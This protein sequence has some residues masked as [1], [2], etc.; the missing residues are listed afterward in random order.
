MSGD[1]TCTLTFLICLHACFSICVHMYVYSRQR[2]ASILAN[3]VTRSYNLRL[4]TAAETDNVF[5]YSGATIPEEDGRL[6]VCNITCE[7]PF[8]Y[9]FL[10]R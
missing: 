5:G 3:P 6:S 9:L 2:R 7:P 10:H 8:L 4:S 1:S